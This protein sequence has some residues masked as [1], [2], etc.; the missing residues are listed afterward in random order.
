MT[1]I[2][3]KEQ[4]RFGIVLS[5]LR[6]NFNSWGLC[7]NYYLTCKETYELQ[8][9]IYASSA[10]FGSWGCNIGLKDKVSTVADDALAMQGART[11]K[12]MVLTDCAG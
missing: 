6:V 8:I 2:F 7:Y 12:A 9:Q 5:S 3:H 10:L 1:A 11:S 4:W